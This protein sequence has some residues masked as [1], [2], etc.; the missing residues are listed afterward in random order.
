MAV[1]QDGVRNPKCKEDNKSTPDLF[2]ILFIYLLPPP[3]QMPDFP[4]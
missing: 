2:N 4:G 1:T 3:V